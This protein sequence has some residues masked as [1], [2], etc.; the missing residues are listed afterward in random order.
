MGINPLVDGERRRG[1]SSLREVRFARS[2]Y[3]PS[4]AGDVEHDALEDIAFADGEFGQAAHLHDL[5]QDDDARHDDG[6]ALRVETDDMPAL[7]QGHELQFF[8][9]IIDIAPRHDGSMHARGVVHFHLLAHGHDAC[10]RYRDSYDA[11]AEEAPFAEL[12]KIAGKL[13]GNPCRSIGDKRG[14]WRVLREEPLGHAS[15]ADLEGQLNSC[16]NQYRRY[17]KQ[18]ADLKAKYEKDKTYIDAK[19]LVERL[20]KI[21]TRCEEL[22][23]EKQN[24]RLR[25]DPIERSL[26]QKKMA[27]NAAK[28]EGAKQV[29]RG[30]IR[31]KEML[32]EESEEWNELHG[33]LKENNLDVDKDSMMV[34]SS[35]SANNDA[36]TDEAIDDL[37][38]SI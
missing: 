15:A 13:G 9:K 31:E 36:I 7:F 27:I 21:K 19:T 38:N 25:L 24:I 22:E 33:D 30:T 20:T 37:F 16:E 10:G 8:Q 6:S 26:S 3:G 1:S 12:G 23:V 18:A 2:R 35:H 34:G 14:A 4:P 29:V 28:L 5:L 11:P 17:K 32:E